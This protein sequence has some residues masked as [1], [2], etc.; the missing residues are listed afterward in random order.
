[1]Y[2]VKLELLDD[3]QENIK[4]KVQLHQA[5]NLRAVMAHRVDERYNNLVRVFQ[6]IMF[7]TTH[8]YFTSFYVSAL[9]RVKNHLNRI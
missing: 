8:Q 6:P 9:K 7:N 5:A 3:L 4:I 1:M 2:I